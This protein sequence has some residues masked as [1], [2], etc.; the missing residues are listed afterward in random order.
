L[1]SESDPPDQQNLRAKKREVKES[2]RSATAVNQEVANA[3]IK[4]LSHF[5]AGQVVE[6]LVYILELEH[7]VD[8]N[9][10]ANNTDAL[11][12]A[13][14]KMFGSAAHVIEGRISESLAKQLGIDPDGKTLDQLVEILKSRIG[15]LAPAAK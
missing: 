5:G 6:S 4:G 2:D 3:V 11:K 10:L 15:D 7:S 13:L 12:A 9:S 1:Q 8:L 14:G